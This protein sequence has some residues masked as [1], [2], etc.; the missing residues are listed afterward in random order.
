MAKVLD[1]KAAHD[2]VS[3]GVTA[4]AGGAA[5]KKVAPSVEAAL[6]LARETAIAGSSG[7]RKT[8]ISSVKVSVGGLDRGGGEP[9][10]TVFRTGQPIDS[11]PKKRVPIRTGGGTCFTIKIGKVS[12]TV[13]IEWES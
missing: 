8:V 5:A 10:T 1:S 2:L 12:V 6:A 11:G 13:C 3:R 4:L 7:K 9:D